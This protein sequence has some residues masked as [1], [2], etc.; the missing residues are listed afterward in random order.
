[1]VSTSAASSALTDGRMM[2]HPYG[3][4]LHPL[5]STE[6]DAE[7]E[8]LTL[9]IWD[10]QGDDAW[11]VSSDQ[12][13]VRFQD[14]APANTEAAWPLRSNAF[15]ASDCLWT[16][17]DSAA[18]PPASSDAHV[19]PRVTLDTAEPPVAK[20]SVRGKSG[21]APARIPSPRPEEVGAKHVRSLRG[22]N[23][24]CTDSSCLGRPKSSLWSVCVGSSGASAW[25]CSTV[26]AR[27]MEEVGGDLL[28]L[29]PMTTELTCGL[30]VKR[31]CAQGCV[32]SVTKGE[33]CAAHSK[34]HSLI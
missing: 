28:K 13:R 27:C 3:H 5:T 11:S 14:E 33:L 18:A 6:A 12:R 23:D 1:M 30:V 16:D 25:D 34:E 32:Q 8:A 20:P 7:A 15:L 9:G 31:C 17:P 21:K 4:I 2:H 22:S 19:E 29:N 26:S 10:P 24:D